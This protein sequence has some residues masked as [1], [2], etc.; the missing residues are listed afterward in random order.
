MICRLSHFAYSTI[1]VVPQTLTQPPPRINASST[2]VTVNFLKAQLLSSITIRIHPSSSHRNSGEPKRRRPAN[3]WSS[4]M[5]ASAQLHGQ[6]NHKPKQTQRP[7]SLRPRT[8]GRAPPE[9]PL[10]TTFRSRGSCYRPDPPF[11]PPPHPWGLVQPSYPPDSRLLRTLPRSYS[12]Y[13]PAAWR[14]STRS[15]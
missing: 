1:I 9:P 11:H 6:F 2:C 14:A 5:T 8:C 4:Y 13:L 15:G 12:S 10:P 3:R 7:Y